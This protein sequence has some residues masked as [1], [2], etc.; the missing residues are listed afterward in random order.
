M[1]GTLCFTLLALYKGKG[2]Q[3]LMLKI[4]GTRKDAALHGIEPGQVV[5]VVTT[6]S[7]ELDA[8]TKYYNKA[9][10]RVHARMLF[11]SDEFNLSR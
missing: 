6:D 2:D 4:E 8:V 10:G 5:R 3:R 1:V 9:D 11:R 7:M